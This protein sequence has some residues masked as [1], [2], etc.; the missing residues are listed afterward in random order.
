MFFI[1]ANLRR[2]H[3]RGEQRLMELFQVGLFR[4]FGFRVNQVIYIAKHL[5][6]AS[7]TQTG[8]PA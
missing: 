5:H 1:G 6:H 3:L 7:V 8:A 2:V 4:K